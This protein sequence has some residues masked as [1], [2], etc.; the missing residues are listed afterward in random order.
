M[1]EIKEE[2]KAGK[3]IENDFI[4]LISLDSQIVDI[5]KEREKIITRAC[6]IYGINPGNFY[7]QFANYKSR[8]NQVY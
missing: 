6:T 4:K 2:F 1:T 7:L 5:E 3:G 8:R